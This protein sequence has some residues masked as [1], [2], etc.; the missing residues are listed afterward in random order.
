MA[1][2]AKLFDVTDYLDS[3]EMIAEYLTAAMEGNDPRHIANALADV[4]RARGGMEL[5]AR[6]TGLSADQLHQAL[7][8]SEPDFAT[9]L[10][11]LQALGLKLSASFATEE[12]IAA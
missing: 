1:L 2:K 4:A 8:T 9:V 11:V 5:L 7:A 12:K 6:D 3:D 10:K